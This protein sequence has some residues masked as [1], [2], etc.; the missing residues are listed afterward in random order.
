M[1]SRAAVFHDK[2]GTLKTAGGL[3]YTAFKMKDGR[4]ISKARSAASKK[5][6]KSNPKF[7][8]F[9]EFAKDN[10]GSDFKQAPK[11]KTKAYKKIIKSSK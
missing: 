5:A 9:V 4:I 10:A 1:S 7:K 11:K 3:D 6:L 8:A 2:T